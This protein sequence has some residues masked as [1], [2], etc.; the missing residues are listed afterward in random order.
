MQSRIWAGSRTGNLRFG[1]ILY[2]PG[3]RIKHV[4]VLNDALVFLLTL[5]DGHLALEVGMLLL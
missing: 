5:I 3:D 1:E 4:Y 2:Q